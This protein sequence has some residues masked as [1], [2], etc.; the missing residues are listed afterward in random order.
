[1]NRKIMTVLLLFL[2][3]LG[4][5]A[6]IGIWG[7]QAKAWQGILG[8]SE[9]IAAK[10]PQVD[11]KYKIMVLSAI[12]EKSTL[13]AEENA[14]LLDYCR[15]GGILVMDFSTI[16]MFSDGKS[17]YDLSSGAEVMGATRYV[18]GAFKGET[19]AL[20]QEIFGE[21]AAGLKEFPAERGPALGGLTTMK[22]L[23]SGDNVAL[24][25][26]NRC[27]KGAFVYL[28]RRVASCEGLYRELLDKLRDPAFL[29]HYF[30]VPKAPEIAAWGNRAAVWQKSFDG[31]VVFPG[32]RPPLDKLTGY[33]T[34]VISV[35][36]GGLNFTESEINVLYEY[37]RNGGRLIMDAAVIGAFSDG[38]NIYD[39]SAGMRI[40]GASRYAYGEFAGQAT[41]L[42]QE[43]FGDKASILNRVAAGRGPALGGL[44]SIHVLQR[45]NN[46]ALLGVN[47]CGAGAF[48]Y[49]A[50]GI[51]PED[52]EY[53]ELLQT[54]LTKLKDNAFLDRYFPLAADNRAAF[55][56]GKRVHLAIGGSK[57]PAAG[58]FLEE[59]L[60]AI[61]G[62]KSFSAGAAHPGQLTI[63]VGRTKEVEKLNLDFASLPKFGYFMVKTPGGDIVLAG[64]NLQ[65]DQYAVNDFLKR[66][67][68]YRRFS[69]S[70][71]TE[72]VPSREYIELPESFSFR[73]APDVPSYTVAWTPNGDFGRNG[74][75]T[76]MSTH[77]MN[78][79]MPPA[80]YAAEH[81]EWYSEIDGKRVTFAKGKLTLWQPCL[82][83]P[84]L[85]R[86]VLEY[87][88][89]YFKENPD[90]LTLPLGVNDGAGD[91]HCAYCKGLDEKHINRYA[92]FYNQAAQALK[93]RYPEKL[94]GFIAYG[95]ARNVPKNITME[96]NILVEVC[97]IGTINAFEEYS[98][99]QD[100]GIKHF[101][102]Y[103]YLYTFGGGYV[104]PRYYPHWV[105]EE[106]QRE[107][108][109]FPVTSMWLEFYP[110]TRIF[111][112][113]RQYVLD[114]LAWNLN[115]DVESLL[116]DYFNNMY[117]PAA[118]PVRQ[119]FDRLEEA[120]SRRPP[121]SAISGW[122]SIVQLENYTGEDLVYL[123]GK[124]AEAIKQAPAGTVYGKRLAMLEKAWQLSRLYIETYLCGTQVEKGENVLESAARGYELIDAINHF[125]MTPEE[126]KEIFTGKNSLNQFRTEQ[127]TLNPLPRLEKYTDRAFDGITRDQLQNRSREQVAQYW[128]GLAA[129]S[130]TENFRKAALTQA[131]QLENPPVNLVSIPGFEVDDQIN[132]DNE[133]QIEK[134]A[135]WTVFKGVKGWSTWQFPNSVTRFYHDRREARSGKYSG[136]IGANQI[137]GS[138]IS[139]VKLEPG[140]RYRLSY[141]VKR[142][143]END[144]KYG[145]LSVRMQGK[146][147]WLDSG[148]AIVAPYPA[149]CVGK[150]VEVTTTF[151]A[152]A[153]DATALLLFAAPQQGEDSMVWIDDVSMVKIYGPA[154]NDVKKK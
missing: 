11:A 149:E 130:R 57:H 119:F 93:T 107:F 90:N 104:V 38:K 84:E 123:D 12:G 30:P 21:K 20:A 54:L 65:A 66:Y 118:V 64:K 80:K 6:E 35:L 143:D 63:H 96:P 79:L 8:E 10:R 83:N 85:P 92:V 82:S 56:G 112:L 88:D 86:L 67:A 100:I 128:R 45:G 14:A 72:I 110:K 15:N 142:N 99:W 115:A 74:R 140:C 27:G 117:G 103:D 48:I 47:R 51:A 2:T 102:L 127:S 25:G 78:K 120:F 5:A 138:L 89:R 26:V 145:G 36:G 49:S 58:K 16:T 46:V 109:R 62:A 113:P 151:S 61:T 22:P 111:E 69:D 28:A 32:G 40:L 132:V 73:E 3:A 50:R 39:L 34:V 68:G 33:P 13:S 108:K 41:P 150:W 137:G 1:M 52:R 60:A 18:Y 9:I 122:K 144:G 152:P 76:A 147:K 94:V 114:E 24:L 131:W 136:G 81:P 31:V 105:A 133:K 55:C 77:S 71:L 98:K 37:C 148:S 87:A 44:E 154:G 59:K 141:F 75:L 95:A 121:R 17:V 126:E 116:N 23:L 146:G 91:C 42:A 43:I 153:E 29:D 125:T 135:D 134:P 101:G 70:V 19:T 139:Y 129:D 106:W 97:S 7:N 53:N 4:T 124:L